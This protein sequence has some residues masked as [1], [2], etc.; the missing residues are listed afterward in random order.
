MEINNEHILKDRTDTV[1]R[2]TLAVEE[3]MKAEWRMI[4]KA[5]L[6]RRGGHLQWRILHAAVAVNTNEP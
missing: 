1:W 6:M 3:V 2:N 4:Y 5:A